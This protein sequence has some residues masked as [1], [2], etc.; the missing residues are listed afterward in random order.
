M[1]DRVKVLIGHRFHNQQRFKEYCYY[2]NRPVGQF[3]PLF[4][5]TKNDILFIISL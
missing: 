4:I 2:D 5:N 1:P 3:C